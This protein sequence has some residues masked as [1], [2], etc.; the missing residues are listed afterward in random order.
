MDKEKLVVEG[1]R[2]ALANLQLSGVSPKGVLI[3]GIQYLMECC[4]AGGLKEGSY[5]EEERQKRAAMFNQAILFTE[6]YIELGFSYESHA[7]LFDRVFK[8][9]G[10]TEDEILLFKQ[11]FAQ[12]LK[13]GKSKI[14]SVIG[15][16]NPR[17]HSAAKKQV[18]AEIIEKV[19]NCEQ[20]EYFY[21]SGREGSKEMDVYQLVV[22]PEGSYFCHVNEQ[23]Y[24][25]FENMG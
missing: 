10:L 15:R 1:V 23:R 7:E 16:W 19:R 8:E 3:S 24:Y 21:Y 17:Y 2:L 4:C 12:K 14:S 5:T 11:R 22:E 6:V 18:V 9:A 13:P 25:E 20:G